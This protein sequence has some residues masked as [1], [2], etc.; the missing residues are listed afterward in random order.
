MF[1]AELFSS[2][3]ERG[4]GR[5]VGRHTGGG[6]MKFLDC[7]LG[8]LL[9]ISAIAFAD[10]TWMDTTL[11]PPSLG[12]E[13]PVR[14]YLPEG[15]DPGGTVDY[16]VI[17]WLHAWGVTHFSYSTYTKIA[18]DSLIS[19]Q[20]IQPVIVVKPNG[21]CEPY[22]GCMWV[23]SLLYGDYEDYVVY[24]LVSFIDSTFC[25][26]SDPEYRCIAGHSMGAA[27][28]MRI[29]LEHT[30]QYKAIASHSGFPDFQVLIP[31]FGS[32]AVAECPETEPPYTYDWGNG[33]YTDCL[34][35]TSGGYS[36]N[37]SAPDSV[38]F[39]L[40][41]NGAVIDSVYALWEL[42]NATSIVKLMPPPINLDIFFDCG[43]GDEW[44]GCY[45]SNCS[46]ADT[47]TA[48]GIEYEFQSLPGVGHGMNLGRFIEEFLFLGEAMT[49]I[50]EGSSLPASVILEP[51]FPNPFTSSTTLSFEL[52]EPG[53]ATLQV[54]DLSG[55][56]VETLIDGE[57][58]EGY[59][60][61]VFNAENYHSGVYLYRLQTISTV[62]TQRCVLIR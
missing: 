55:R 4:K 10:G 26:V 32:E 24:D 57:L 37:L 46:Y 56:L 31:L 35:L 23:N 36:P 43:S 6:T 7:I 33:P 61:V 1:N 15:Y 42:N 52:H 34:F 14:I 44:T 22:D 49:G 47:L 59:H 5:E 45:E 50:A 38:D 21:F 13:T 62:Q 17:Y 25:T 58:Q 30:D 51:A 28:S 8:L 29:A 53:H 39:L 54:F 2:G 12:F 20:Q 19:S 18:L 3:L 40:D 11:V 48:L 41:E 60:S 27:G 16:P 9:I